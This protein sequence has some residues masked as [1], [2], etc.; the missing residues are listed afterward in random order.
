[1]KGSKTGC[2]RAWTGVWM[3]DEGERDWARIGVVDGRGWGCGWNTEGA[4]TG[5]VWMGVCG[6]VDERGGA[7]LGPSGGFGWKMRGV[8]GVWMEDGG[9]RDWVWTGVDK[10]VDGRWRGARLGADWVGV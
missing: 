8:D 4:E 9:E 1:M 3:E 5:W 10:G 7:R 2:G 6:G